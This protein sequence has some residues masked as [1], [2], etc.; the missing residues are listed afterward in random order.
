V[1]EPGF[2]FVCVPSA[3]VGLPAQ[4]VTEMLRDGEIALLA[5]DGGFAAMPSGG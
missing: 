4:W 2:H 5:D 1:S 3:L